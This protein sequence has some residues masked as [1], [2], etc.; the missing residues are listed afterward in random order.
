[1]LLEPC[2]L[3]NISARLSTA[4]IFRHG[5]PSFKEIKSPAEHNSILD[6]FERLG[7]VNKSAKDSQTLIHLKKRY[8]LEKKCLNCAIGHHILR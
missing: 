5:S 4:N 3:N 2:F 1:M 6:E 7:F 8:C